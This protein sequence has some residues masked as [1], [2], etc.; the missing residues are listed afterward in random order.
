MH[1]ASALPCPCSRPIGSY[2]STT[3]G[4]RAAAQDYLTPLKL[5]QLCGEPDLSKVTF[6]EVAV[7]TTENSL[8]N[9]GKCMVVTALFPQFIFT[10]SK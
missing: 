10:T 4:K 6:L 5:V 1:S 2:A 8:G 9:F 3:D 7:N